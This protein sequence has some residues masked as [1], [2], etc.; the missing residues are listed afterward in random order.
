MENR[1]LIRI[2]PRDFIGD[3]NTLSIA[4]GAKDALKAIDDVLGR[5]N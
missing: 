1:T 2:N 4:M 3:D 5:K